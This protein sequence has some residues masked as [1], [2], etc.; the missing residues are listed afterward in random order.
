MTRSE[1]RAR[2][3]KANS[4]KDARWGDDPFT[5][6]HKL[7]HV[8]AGCRCDWCLPAKRRARTNDERNAIN[9]NLKD[10]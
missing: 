6:A 7:R 2:T 1:R 3:A 4:K 10:Q 8:A 5:P 9:D